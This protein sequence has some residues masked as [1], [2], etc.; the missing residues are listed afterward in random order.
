[1]LSESD[2]GD[3]KIDFRADIPTEDFDLSKLSF[4]VGGLSN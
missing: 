2:D 4:K 1:M 3:C